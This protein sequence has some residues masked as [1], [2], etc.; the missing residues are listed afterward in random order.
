MVYPDT[1]TPSPPLCLEVCV[2]GVQGSAACEKNFARYSPSWVMD[3]RGVSMGHYQHIPP[4]AGNLTIGGIYHCM[5]RYKRRGM[6][7]KIFRHYPLFYRLWTWYSF[8]QLLIDRIFSGN[9]H[10]FEILWRISQFYC[11]FKSTSYWT[12]LFFT[13]KFIFRTCLVI[14]YEISLIIR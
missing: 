10:T 12:V 14:W 1:S 13:S 4:C 6:K 9:L 7:P 8:H 3:F 5:Q 2:G 11:W